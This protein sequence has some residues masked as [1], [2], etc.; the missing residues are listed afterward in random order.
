V[1]LDFAVSDPFDVEQ[2]THVGV[3]LSST[4]GF[5]GLPL[6]WEQMLK[7]A[8]LDVDTVGDNKDTLVDVINVQDKFNK[9]KTAVDNN[10]DLIIPVPL[11]E[12]C[13][14]SVDEIINK[15]DNPE[16]LFVNFEKI[17]EGAAGEVFV[18][19]YVKLNEDIAIK[20][21]KLNDKNV[22]QL[23]FEIYIMKTSNH[24]N[25]VKYYDCFLIDKQLWVAMEYMGGGC[26]TDVLEVHQYLK[27]TEEQIAFICREVLKGLKYFHYNNRIHR[28]IKSD[29]ILLGTD[30]SIKLADFGYAAQLTKE[31]SNRS[32]IVGTPYWMAP[33]LIKGEDYDARVDIW[34]LGIMMI[35]MSDGE[36]PYMDLPP[37]RAL[38]FIT[39]KGVPPLKVTTW[40]TEFFEFLNKCLSD[41]SDR[42]NSSQLLE[43]P[44]LN[45]ASKQ[46]EMVY[47]V[48]K[49]QKLREEY[50]ASSDDDSNDED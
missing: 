27:L 2:V 13:N 37:L 7:D 18:A 14:V 31:R 29:N 38:F 32:T 33:E 12:N 5:S 20:K 35:E 46:S 17:G 47:V 24:S 40:S 4:S 45:K 1:D 21:I 50:L 23:I 41:S 10:E 30:G 44:F 39:T 26:L 42:S 15:K 9:S 19:T 49:T 48:V 11:P 22:E 34:S 6:D 36:P 43:H 3:D 16:D 8:Q 28:D 25:I